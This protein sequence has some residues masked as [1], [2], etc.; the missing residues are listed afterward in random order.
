M[1][2]IQYD[3]IRSFILLTIFVFFLQRLMSSSLKQREKDILHTYSVHS[4]QTSYAL[5][6]QLYVHGK[7]QFF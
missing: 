6:I 3:G 1:T 4:Y 5:E 2:F 7:K